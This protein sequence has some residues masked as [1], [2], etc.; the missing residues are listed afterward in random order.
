MILK[1]VLSLALLATPARAM[2]DVEVHPG[3]TSRELFDYLGPPDEIEL[4][5]GLYERW[6]WTIVRNETWR[7]YQV[8]TYIVDFAAKRAVDVLIQ[9][10][11]VRYKGN[12]L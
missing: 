8:Y 11:H 3:K 9:V 6:T 2:D 5:A 12:H 10:R 7:G 4:H 1:L